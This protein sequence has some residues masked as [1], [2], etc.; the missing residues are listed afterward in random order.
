MENY[1]ENGVKVWKILILNTI[2]IKNIHLFAR[3]DYDSTYFYFWS[4]W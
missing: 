2:Y 3:F 4:F 1:E